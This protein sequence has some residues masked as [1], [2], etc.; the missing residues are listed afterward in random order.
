[1]HASLPAS[2]IL[3]SALLMAGAAPDLA[4]QTR[5]TRNFRAG[6]TTGVGYTGA[7]PEALAGAGAFHFFGT[8]GVGVFGDVKLTLP[9]LTRGGNYCPPGLGAC[10]TAWVASERNDQDLGIT[11]EWI[12][13]NAGALY[14]LTPEFAVL[15][16]AG[17]ARK[18][19][20]REFYHDEADPAERIT[21]TGGYYVDDDEGW[22]P[23][24][25]AG[26]LFRAGPR[27]AFR[28][29]YETAPGG[30]SFGVYF[31]P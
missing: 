17:I 22:T 30:M 4:A 28:F 15:A 6:M 3:G 14:A 10:S 18:E 8:T 13:A 20:Y 9:S 2:I 31:V 25:V 19:S 23:Q 24:L 7:L 27:L 21:P 29:G 5:P 12:V 16:G 26:M 1:M 11:D